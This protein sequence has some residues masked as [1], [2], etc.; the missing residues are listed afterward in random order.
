[1]HTRRLAKNL[2]WLSMLALSS[3]CSRAAPGASGDKL[4]IVEMHEVMGSSLARGHP[5]PRASLPTVH[6]AVIQ[7][8][9]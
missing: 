2:L 3:S 4:L 8:P 1:M 6:Q 5:S 9:S 7:E